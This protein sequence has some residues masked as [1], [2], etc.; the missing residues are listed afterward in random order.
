MTRPSSGPSRRPL[1]A[2]AARVTRGGS[3]APAAEISV[4]VAPAPAPAAV[5][6][7][8]AAHGPAQQ[9]RPQRRM[10]HQKSRKQSH[11]EN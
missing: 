7:V 3:F 6:V 5:A 9:D 8:A 1:A 11:P 4:V 2:A 10:E